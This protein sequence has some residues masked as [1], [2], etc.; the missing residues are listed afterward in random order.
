MRSAFLSLALVVAAMSATAPFPALA[1]ESVRAAAQPENQA[2]NVDFTGGPATEYI[3]AIRKADPEAN[4]VV[5]GE[6]EQITIPAVRLRNA[7]VFSALD[8][9]NSAP[10]QQAGVSI[11]E[12]HHDGDRSP[13][14]TITTYLKSPDK[15]QLRKPQTT[16][17]SMAELLD[18]KLK[19]ADAL[20]AIE[21]ALELVK[22][23]YDPAQ[24]RFHEETGLL[25]ARGS[26]EQVESIQQV[27]AQLHQRAGAIR[28]KAQQ[29]D[30]QARGENRSQEL[31][32]ARAENES[33]RMKAT[34]AE[35]SAQ[36]LQAEVARL[37]DSIS[38]LET[39]MRQL[40]AERD[41]L[42]RLAAESRQKTGG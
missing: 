13:V 37:R 21:A 12:I 34:Q 17:I 15:P 14:F 19:P 36:M 5:L 24:V 30:A 26:P 29:A 4:I 35:I 39:E 3:A 2:L 11:K 31:L 32:A 9:L 10:H 18:E 33:L 27:I 42:E 7:D 22:G 28:H 8:L 16:V 6:L 41:A 20:K 23:E 40:R 1:Q 25:I 38:N